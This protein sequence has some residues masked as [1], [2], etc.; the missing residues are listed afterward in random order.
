[1]LRK[2]YAFLILCLV[3]SVIYAQVAEFQ[4]AVTRFKGTVLV[5]AKV[6][7]IDHKATVTNDEKLTGTMTIQSPDKMNISVADG[8]EQLDMNGCDFTM[9]TRGREHKTN[10][11]RDNQFVAFQTVLKSIINADATM[12][13]NVPGISLHVN[14]DVLTITMDPTVGLERKKR[15]MFT[16]FVVTLDVRKCELRSLCMNGRGKNYTE[17]TFSDFVYKK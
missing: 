6:T 15:M 1:M 10:S 3:S 16:S 2:T 11:R 7:R 14:G 5:T 9:L 8:R 12:L 13:D 17:Y 4:K